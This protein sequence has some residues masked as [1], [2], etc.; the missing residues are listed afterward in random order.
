MCSTH[1]GLY[2]V[3]LGVGKG[4]RLVVAVEP[5]VETRPLINCPIHG[6]AHALDA[7]REC[8]E[9]LIAIVAADADPYAHL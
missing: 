6:E 7:T 9:A 8:Y 1:Y 3:G 2:G 4:Q 5:G